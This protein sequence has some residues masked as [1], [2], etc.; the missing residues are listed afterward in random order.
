MS[1]IT[2]ILEKRDYQSY[3]GAEKATRL[4]L[5]LLKE[6]G[7]N[8]KIIT[9]NKEFT[10]GKEKS[11]YTS[12]LDVPTKI[13]LWINLKKP[14]FIKILEKH[15]KETDILYIP[16]LS[17]PVIPHLANEKKK[18]I[19]HL[20]DYQPITFSS[21]IY[22]NEKNSMS[23]LNDMEKTIKFEVNN[24]EKISRT[25]KSLLAT[26]LN[27]LVK[28]WIKKADTIL[29]VSKRQKTI[30]A[31]LAP[32][33]KAKINVIYNPL[34]KTPLH[35]TS[36]KEP[37]MTYFGGDNYLKGFKTILKASKIFE[38]HQ[39][40][41]FLLTNKYKKMYDQLFL[42]LN[43]KYPNSY[44]N[45]GYVDSKQLQRIQIESKAVLFPSIWEEPLPYVVTEAMLS[46]TIPI[47][48]NIGGVPEI[49]NG[50]YAEKTLFQCNDL[51]DFIQKIEHVLSL[52]PEE[53]L[54]IG[55][56][57]REETEK[58]FHENEIRKDL[59]IFNN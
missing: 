27:R 39:D 34:P 56:S 30:I 6:E 10:N 3:G 4:I 17:Y 23:I 42:R 24:N 29:C 25:I 31:D 35:E 52:T 1:N 57:L 19:V 14:S 32:E 51:S 21:A 8:I 44:V 46:G 28:N 2:V 12:L 49:V 59:R 48:S 11:I 5:N 54:E 55:T 7:H 45:V 40:F 36:Q 37:Y 26:P 9:G 18:I 41:R 43:K 53:L 15:T 47:A 20:H 16:R 58:K 38:K 50:T 33:L 13:H 22:Q